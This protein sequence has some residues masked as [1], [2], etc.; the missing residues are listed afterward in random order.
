[1][2]KYMVITRGY[3]PSHLGQQ[4]NNMITVIEADL[5]GVDDNGF[6]YFYKKHL[7]TTV[8]VASFNKGDWIS[9]TRQESNE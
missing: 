2:N 9:V 4:T 1:M 8:L 6:L 3:Y 7:N 5:Y